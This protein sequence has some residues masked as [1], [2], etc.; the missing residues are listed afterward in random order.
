MCKYKILW[1][2]ADVILDKKKEKDKFYYLVQKKT[3]G[4]LQWEPKSEVQK[5]LINKYQKS[6]GLCICQTKA[7]QKGE[8][9][10]PL[11]PFDLLNSSQ[12]NIFHACICAFVHVSHSIH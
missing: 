3:A 4:G 9:V 5:D 7:I 6:V 8:K 2:I 12:G 11:S 1:C 10:S